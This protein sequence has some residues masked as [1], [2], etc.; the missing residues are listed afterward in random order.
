MNLYAYVGNDPPEAV[1]PYGRDRIETELFTD[2]EGKQKAKVW[3][4]DTDDTPYLVLKKILTLGM[5]SRGEA[6]PVLV[7]IMNADLGGPEFGIVT[8]PNGSITT[9][10]RVREES[11]AWGTNW[12]KFQAGDRAFDQDQQ[13]NGAW[14]RQTQAY[15][16]GKI[17]EG[18]RKWNEVSLSPKA[19]PTPTRAQRLNDIVDETDMQIHM[20]WTCFDFYATAPLAL[21][22]QVATV[23]QFRDA[24]YLTR[25]STVRG[26]A[27]TWRVSAQSM[28]HI[29]E[30]HGA[31][32]TSGAS[33]FYADVNIRQLI[34]RAELAQNV[35]RKESYGG[36]TVNMV[37]DA[38]HTI[39][40]D[41]KARSGTRMYTVVTN[42]TDTGVDVISAYPGLPAKP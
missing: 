15:V 23:R 29:L 25:Y 33:R 36:K 10:E 30:R 40:W 37:L 6:T 18:S 38:G 5:A 14:G 8:L 11:E 34:A 24:A 32:S 1:D 28:A 42:M 20:L 22:A 7:G 21:A 26:E 19:A 39:G 16:W 35:A 4:I 3:Y 27:A 41:A 31:N 12:E 17:D 13:P 9:L 2:V